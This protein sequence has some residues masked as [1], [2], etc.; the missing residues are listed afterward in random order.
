MD[1]RCNQ[2]EALLPAYALEALDVAERWQVEAHL[3]A[4]PECNAALEQYKDAASGLLMAA[5]M[6]EP[7]PRLRARLIASIAEPGPVPVRAAGRS[8][9]R[10]LFGLA[11]SL[12]AAFMLITGFLIVEVRELASNQAQLAEQ[13]QE[14]QTVVGLYSYPTTVSVVV[15]G[16][17]AYGTFLYEPN[18]PVSVLYAWGLDRL[19]ADATYQIWLIEPGGGRVSGGLFQVGEDARFVRLL[20]RAPE[21]ISSYSAIGV[22]VEPAGG[23]EGPTGPKV[24]GADL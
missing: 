23:S 22:T 1:E 18:L 2:I 3:Q 15:E 11:S 19:E 9:N 8:R 21:N 17:R 4:C 24:L 5:P 14:E 16:Q 7:P 10:A 20:V 13:L 12:L 6:V